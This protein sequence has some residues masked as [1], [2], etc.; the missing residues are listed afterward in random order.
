MVSDKP[1]ISTTEPSYWRDVRDIL[2]IGGCIGVIVI[3]LVLI[4]SAVLNLN[5]AD[6]YTVKWDYESL[7]NSPAFEQVR[8]S[9]FRTGHRQVSFRVSSSTRPLQLRLDRSFK[10]INPLSGV[11]TKDAPIM[12]L[13]KY[14]PY[15]TH[16]YYQSADDFLTCPNGDTWVYTDDKLSKAFVVE[17]GHAGL[18][19]WDSF[20]SK[21]KL[22]SIFKLSGKYIT[23]TER[24]CRGNRLYYEFMS[25]GEP[26]A[27]QESCHFQEIDPRSIALE[28][29]PRLKASIRR[30]MIWGDIKTGMGR[31][32]I[33][34]YYHG[35]CSLPP[36]ADIYVYAN[37]N[38]T[39]GFV[40]V[41]SKAITRSAPARTV[42]PQ[43]QN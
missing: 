32:W 15:M 28:F 25:P 21:L 31:S 43:T 23:H 11:L 1:Q 27:L 6:P 9:G 40:I 3:T 12:S 14:E 42:R 36:A 13:W 22:S 33:T 38:L 39:H 20:F 34:K 16:C 37:D 30:S 26:A 17:Q 35:H 8:V 24:Y 10:A 29:P 41:E 2:A 4:I 7:F 19:E 5:W 18:N